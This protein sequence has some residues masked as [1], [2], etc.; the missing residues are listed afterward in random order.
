MNTVKVLVE[1][2]GRNCYLRNAGGGSQ[3]VKVP[4]AFYCDGFI[5]S[6]SRVIRFW[7]ANNDFINV[8]VKCTEL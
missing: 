1:R 5:L 4:V 7:L 3:I 8:S 6:K 2:V